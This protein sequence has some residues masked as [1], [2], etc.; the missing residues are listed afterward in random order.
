MASD[1]G[2]HCL[3]RSAY[4]NTKVIKGKQSSGIVQRKSW[5]LVDLGVLRRLILVYTVCPGLPVQIL[6]LYRVNSP[7][8][9]YKENPGFWLIWGFC[10]V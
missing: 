7:E 2:L 4:P 5:V 6:R 8:V 9:L 10:G 1:L 3:P